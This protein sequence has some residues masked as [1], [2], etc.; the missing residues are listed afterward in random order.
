MFEPY[1]FP[2]IKGVVS[3]GIGVE[4]H[5]FIL[6]TGNIP[7]I[8]VSIT[9]IILCSFINTISHGRCCVSY[10]SASPVI[11]IIEGIGNHLKF[12]FASH[13]IN[14]IYYI[15]HTLIDNSGELSGFDI[16]SDRAGY[17]LIQPVSKPWHKIS[18]VLVTAHW[19]LVGFAVAGIFLIGRIP[20]A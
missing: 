19:R 12:S 16:E 3:G 4:I 13:S 1:S 15:R 11:S 9:D 5:G 17:I 8:S 14:H 2:L 7:G 6:L 10:S 20:A 18:G